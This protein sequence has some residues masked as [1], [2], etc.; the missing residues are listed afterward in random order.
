MAPPLLSPE[1][2]LS[3]PPPE[4]GALDICPS[5]WSA[6]EG[7]KPLTRTPASYLLEQT[8]W[9]PSSRYLELET[10]PLETKLSFPLSQGHSKAGKDQGQNK[11]SSQVGTDG[12]PQQD[13]L[14]NSMFRAAHQRN[15]WP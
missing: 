2:V 15:T 10:A 12:K 8:T 6:S 13:A 1:A 5:P 3:T 7:A 11:D 9:Q 14:R 4:G